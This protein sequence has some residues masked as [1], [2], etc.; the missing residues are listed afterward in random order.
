MPNLFSCE[1]VE[2]YS[3]VCGSTSGLA[4][5]AIGARISFARG[6]VV[7]VFQLRF[8]LDIEAV[9]TLVERILD[10]FARFADAGEGALL[11][12]AAG[13]EHAKKFAAGNDVES[14]AGIGQAI[15]RSRRFEFALTA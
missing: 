12:I 7:D 1:P 4:R 6:N 8:A 3:C 11:R 2:M 15:L 5:K 13:L 10:F 14:G 9:N